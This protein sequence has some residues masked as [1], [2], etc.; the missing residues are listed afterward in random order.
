MTAPPPN[1]EALTP[2]QRAM[3]AIEKLQA[4]L[5][6]LERARHEPIAVV[7]IG[8]RFPSADG[9]EAFWQLLCDGR[10]AVREVP[11]DRWDA[12]A[13]YNP[14]PLVPGTSVSRW[15]A[16]L[17]QVDA[18]D[19]TFFGI[20]P[21]RAAAMDPQQR[22]LLEVAWEALDDAGL[23]PARRGGSPTGV[24]VGNTTSDYGWLH[25][26]DDLAR[27]DALARENMVRSALATRVAYELDLR[28]P[29][30]VVDAA[31]ASSLLAI[32]L[33]CQSLRNQECNLALAGGVN[34][35]LSPHMSVPLSQ[36]RLL[37]PTGRCRTFDA[38]ADGYVR[39]EGVG[40]VV[41]ERL[42]DALAHGD[43]IL[44]VVRGSAVNQDGRATSFGVPSQ[45][46]QVQLLRRALEEA[47]VRPADVEYVEVHGTGTLFG[48]AIEVG[49]LGEVLG[50]ARPDGRPC[51]LGALKTN[52]GH[53]EAAAGVA[54]FIKAVLC[55]ERGYLPP[56]L[57]QQTRSPEIDL[58]AHT[59]EIPREGRTWTGDA[60]RIA[61]VS[62][63]GAGGANVHVV[64]APAPPAPATPSVP[65]DRYLIPLS[66]HQAGV[67]RE[68]AQRYRAWLAADG[69]QVNVADIAYSAAARRVHLRHRLAILAASA[70]QA[71]QELDRYLAGT[72]SGG[73]VAGVVPRPSATPP[74]S[75]PLAAN[76]SDDPLAEQAHR[77]V[78]GEPVD[79]SSYFPAPRP[80]VRVPSYPWQRERFWL[81]MERRTRD[82][83]PDCEP[84]LQR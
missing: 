1:L 31:C 79:W 10:D 83:A 63:L 62:A 25:Y 37:S 46:A 71:V 43:R 27:L 38:S 42:S 26:A 82:A 65:Q 49:A 11:V 9:P 15:G 16:F 78:Q 40:L 52:I 45:A 44:A 60:P 6:A 75:P 50:H 32:H 77:Y 39:G 21:L 53:L 74:A 59:L 17:D 36:S 48:D 64:L 29:S 20:A 56:N 28:G 80:P 72:D 54:A 12:A 84:L 51:V 22:L 69:A 8:C 76:T 61:G 30:L 67:L 73:W 2:L 35:L 66:A 18:F 55:I 57:H 33:A 34:L 68:M 4:K 19:R 13:F 7:G 14:D 24:F 81:G 3:L 23:P 5:D 47:R 41:L 70:Q 58:S